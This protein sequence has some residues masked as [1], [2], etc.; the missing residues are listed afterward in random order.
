MQ[1]ALLEVDPNFREGVSEGVVRRHVLAPSK[2]L[3][4]GTTNSENLSF[5]QQAKL[6]EASDVHQAM[7]RMQLAAAP[8]AA[9]TAAAGSSGARERGSN[10][11]P[12]TPGASA[13][14]QS[15]GTRE[16]DQRATAQQRAV[17]A[18]SIEARNGPCLHSLPVYAHWFRLDAVHEIE[19]NANVEF[20]NGTSSLKTPGSYVEMRNCMIALYR[21]EPKKRL[22]FATCRQHV[23]GDLMAI[24][25]V[26]RF[27]N[28]WS[29]INWEAG[30]PP[31]RA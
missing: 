11:E 12:A 23:T 25:R 13:A 17:S 10:P 14:A 15:A 2:R 28:S 4:E 16:S 6:H 8:P 30:P 19:R 21:A 22:S 9:D 27:L 7:T 5:G 1:Q 24:K 3:R 26:W 18:E 31:V 20:F 29:L